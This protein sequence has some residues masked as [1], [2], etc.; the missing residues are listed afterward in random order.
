[1]IPVPQTDPKQV[2]VAPVCKIMPKIEIYT[3]SWCGYCRMAKSL[4][5]SAGCQF[6][7]YDIDASAELQQEMFQR[8]R[9][10][11]VPQ[12]LI[13]DHPLGGYVDLARLHHSGALAPM[14]RDQCPGPDDRG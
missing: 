12:V 10:R 4:L 14:L 9:G 2:T 6:T 3:R 7:E 5:Q 1:M 11:T 13:N 8:T